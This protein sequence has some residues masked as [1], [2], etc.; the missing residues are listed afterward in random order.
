MKRLLTFLLLLL[1][2]LGN[3]LFAQQ[4]YALKPYAIT[5]P[6]LTTAQQSTS[7]LQ[8]AGNIVYN[9]DEQKMAIHNGSS[10]QYIAPQKQA[11]LRMERLFCRTRSGRF[12]QV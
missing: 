5:L 9:T 7:A 2:S 4:T 8:Q 10:W 3:S 12:R 6:R 1:T 11:S